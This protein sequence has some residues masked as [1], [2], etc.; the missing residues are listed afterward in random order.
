M[1]MIKREAVS[2]Y[3]GIMKRVTEMEFVTHNEKK[4]IQET[5]TLFI[6]GIPVTSKTLLRPAGLNDSLR[7]A[8]G[9]MWGTY[10]ATNN[11]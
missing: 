3:G 2:K 7:I 10:D 11:I 6:M 5:R 4:L 8:M 1:R 9:G